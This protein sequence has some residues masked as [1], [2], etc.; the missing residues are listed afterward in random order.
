MLAGE[1][2][3]TGRLRLGELKPRRYKSNE[4]LE[5][6][7]TSTVRAPVAWIFS[8]LSVSNT[9][10]SMSFHH[11]A[12]QQRMLVHSR[13]PSQEGANSSI[14]YWSGL[15]PFH[16]SSGSLYCPGCPSRLVAAARG[17]RYGR[18]DSSSFIVVPCL[19]PSRFESVMYACC[20]IHPLI[21]CGFSPYSKVSRKKKASKLYSRSL[22]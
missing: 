8:L 11:E 20:D 5:R 17:N 9:S 12:K 6:G 22:E 14:F 18:D 16:W 4:M 1:C 10:C 2:C 15:I 7:P 3:T 19:P 13:E 21:H